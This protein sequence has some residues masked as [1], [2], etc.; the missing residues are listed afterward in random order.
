MGISQ[1]F[2]PLPFLPSTSL[3]SGADNEPS[4]CKPHGVALDFVSPGNGTISIRILVGRNRYSHQQE[5]RGKDEWYGDFPKESALFR[6]EIGGR[7]AQYCLTYPS[8]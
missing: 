8:L 2:L 1:I 7:L 3:L 4:L 5:G 6:I